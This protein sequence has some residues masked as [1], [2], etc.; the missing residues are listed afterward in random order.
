MR[1]QLLP[2]PSPEQFNRRERAR[3]GRSGWRLRQ[4]HSRFVISTHYLVS[5]GRYEPTGE[6]AG[7]QRPRRTRS[8]KITASFKPRERLWGEENFLVALLPGFMRKAGVTGPAQARHG[9]PL[10][11]MW[12]SN[13]DY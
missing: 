9:I 10:T 7:W 1:E 11:Q 4:P 13:I 5:L 3:L 2:L 12:Y 8:P 6:G